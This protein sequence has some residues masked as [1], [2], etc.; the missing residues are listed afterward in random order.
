MIRLSVGLVLIA[1]GTSI[2]GLVW[3]S[4]RRQ[5]SSDGYSYLDR[6]IMMAGGG[7]SL[8]AVLAGLRLLVDTF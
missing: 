7:L 6:N 2:F 8:G 3:R 5:R 1:L 4:W